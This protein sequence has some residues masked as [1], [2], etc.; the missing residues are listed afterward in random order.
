LLFFHRRF[1]D[2]S[3]IENTRFGRFS[4]MPFNAIAIE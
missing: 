3:T 1:Y 4:P 2:H